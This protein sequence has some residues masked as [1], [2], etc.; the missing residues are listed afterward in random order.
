MTVL[1]GVGGVM[2]RPNDIG[3]FRGRNELIRMV[4]KMNL[5]V[6]G[7]TAVLMTV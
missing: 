5:P 6:S 3:R 1:K 4:Q 2:I 7:L